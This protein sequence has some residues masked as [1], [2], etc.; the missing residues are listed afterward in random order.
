MDVAHRKYLFF[1]K[2]G[3]NEELF[4]NIHEHVKSK[5]RN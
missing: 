4:A 1:L 5:R 3:T 2:N